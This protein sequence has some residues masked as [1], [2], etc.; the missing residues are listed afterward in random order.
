MDDLQ[1]FVDVTLSSTEDHLN[2]KKLTTLR[3]VGNAVADF[4]AELREVENTSRMH[5]FWKR[6][7]RRRNRHHEQN[8][9]LDLINLCS[10][11]L[12]ALDQHP[13]LPQFLVKYII[14]ID[15]NPYHICLCVCVCVCQ[16][17]CLYVTSKLLM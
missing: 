12:L 9:S 14:I 10:N 5:L 11:F 8:E 4:I 7:F 3:I 16:S 13:E 2:I 1:A 15:F 17:L 6:S